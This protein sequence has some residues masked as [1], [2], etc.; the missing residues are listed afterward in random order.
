MSW[1]KATAEHFKG[2][3]E[4]FSFNPDWQSFRFVELANIV[5]YNRDAFK[6][7]TKFINGLEKTWMKDAAAAKAQ[8]A[9]LLGFSEEKARAYLHAFNAEAFDKAQYAV[10]EEARK[11]MPHEVAV[12]ADTLRRSTSRARMPASAAPRSAPRAL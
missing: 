8:A 7:N 6:D 2:T 9:A 12:L 11:L 3:P 10:G 5:D 1:E 4:L